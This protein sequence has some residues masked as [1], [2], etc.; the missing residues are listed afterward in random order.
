MRLRIGNVLKAMR[1]CP[2]YVIRVS[3]NR[4]DGR[5]SADGQLKLSGQGN[6]Q[7]IHRL[8]V[9]MCGAN[10]ADLYADVRNANI[11]TINLPHR[12]HTLQ[13]AASLSAWGLRTCLSVSVHGKKK[14]RGYG[15]HHVGVSSHELCF[16]F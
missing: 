1:R 13:A 15:Q 12:S 4:Y 10:A 11:I 5:I 2:W 6:K 16:S 7:V 8:G 14:E 3:R 9:R